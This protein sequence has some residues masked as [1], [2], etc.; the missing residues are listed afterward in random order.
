MTYA[1]RS[2]FLV[3]AA[4]VVA[5]VLAGAA[6]ADYHGDAHE[7]AAASFSTQVATAT[8]HAGFSAGADAHAMAVTHLG[9]VL[10]CF[11]GEA[12]EHFDG[13]WGHPCGGQG[14]GI[15]ADLDGHPMQ[16]ELAPLVQAAHELARQG[17]QL[18]SLAAVQRAAAGVQAL[19]ELIGAAI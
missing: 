13:S 1:H 16:A 17:V 8:T 6:F 14:M 7:A 19:L 9:H 15:A 5:L 12:G 4:L 10:N 3:V 2:S 11:E 18:D